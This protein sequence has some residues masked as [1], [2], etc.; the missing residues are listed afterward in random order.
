MFVGTSLNICPAAGI[1]RYAPK[2][3]PI[4]LIAPEDV[5]IAD[6]RITQIR[7]VATKGMET[8]RRM[9]GQ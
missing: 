9:L 6:P 7:Q 2:G 4:Y 5:A 1:Y 8:F 3:I